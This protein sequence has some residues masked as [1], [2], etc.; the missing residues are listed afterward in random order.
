MSCF[1][2]RPSQQ[3]LIGRGDLTCGDQGIRTT[4]REGRDIKA[5]FDRRV[6]MQSSLPPGFEQGQALVER[7]L[8][9]LRGGGCSRENARGL[10]DLCLEMRAEFAGR[11]GI[12]RAV[13]VAGGNG[14]DQRAYLLPCL[15]SS[16]PGSI[17]KEPNRENRVGV[18]V[19]DQDGVIYRV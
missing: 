14:S 11:H 9:L 16:P 8:K 17:L 1:V 15:G 5:A 12:G 7:G 18:N 10:H 13:G 6:W 4:D 2:E 3:P 19:V